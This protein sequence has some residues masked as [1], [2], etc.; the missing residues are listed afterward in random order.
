MAGHGE[1]YSPGAPRLLSSPLKA[2]ELGGG[3]LP[4]PF[5]GLPRALDHLFFGCTALCWQLRR[6]STGGDRQ[7]GGLTQTF[8]P[9]RALGS[10]TGP[11][12]R[13][14]LHEA[15]GWIARTAWMVWAR[16]LPVPLHAG[17]ALAPSV[18]AHSVID[19]RASRVV[20]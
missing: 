17:G 9:K 16:D 2:L 11:G 4:L 7:V 19:S 20:A 15:L 3:S 1:I 12:I 5:G 8:P 13:R 6:G 14:K 18:L 10:R